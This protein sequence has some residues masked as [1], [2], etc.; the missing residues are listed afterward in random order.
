MARCPL[1]GMTM[2]GLKTIKL[3]SNS[4][5]SQPPLGVAGGDR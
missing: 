3:V 1:A 5:Q 4:S 2:S